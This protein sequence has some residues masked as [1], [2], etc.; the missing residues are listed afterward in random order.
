M[1]PYRTENIEIVTTWV[2]K[3]VQFI[4]EL[5]EILEQRK[6]LFVPGA[7]T[8]GKKQVRDQF[9]RGRSPRLPGLLWSEDCVEITFK[10][11]EFRLT[12]AQAN[13]MK[14]I[15]R[16]S[17]G[18][19]VLIPTQ[20]VLDA[21]GRGGTEIRQIFR[22]SPIWQTLLVTTR[23]PKGMVRINLAWDPQPRKRKR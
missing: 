18:G 3:L 5:K 2:K 15:I 10:D 23:T 17:L 13:M 9:S 1:E 6:K 7:T 20:A 4:G 19:P 11:R 21:A 14:E 8:N 16:R 22:G 12:V